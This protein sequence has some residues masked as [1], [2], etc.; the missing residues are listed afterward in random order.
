MSQTPFDPFAAE[1]PV[2]FRPDAYPDGEACIVAYH[3]DLPMC[4]AEGKDEASARARL[5]QVR[6]VYLQSLLD[7]G[8]DIP[9]PNPNA[10]T[11]VVREASIDSA[12][13]T[14]GVRVVT[15]PGGTDV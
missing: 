12:Y 15:P 10:P 1:Y 6:R 4:A 2:V 13:R 5:A 8:R 11:I 3:P 14:A 7:A 9:R